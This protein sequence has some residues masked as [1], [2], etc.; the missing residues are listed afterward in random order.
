MLSLFFSFLFFSFHFLSFPFPFF[1]SIS[2]LCNTWLV[3]LCLHQN[4]VCWGGFFFL[5]FFFSLSEGL[6]HALVLS[7]QPLLPEA[8][9]LLTG[10][11]GGREIKGER[12]YDLSY[13]SQQNFPFGSWRKDR[14]TTISMDG[15]G[16]FLGSALDIDYGSSQTDTGHQR[17]PRG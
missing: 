13:W 2:L 3:V 4:G 16:V 14:K 15:T 1:F 10:L 7:L 12:R 9:W 6:P 5:S 11:L 17:I 8:T